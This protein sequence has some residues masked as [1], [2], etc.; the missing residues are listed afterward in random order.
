[1]LQLKVNLL[2]FNNKNWVVIPGGNTVQQILD[3][4]GRIGPDEFKIL[5]MEYVIDD[6][7]GSPDILK[8]GEI[9]S[10][11]LKAEEISFE[12]YEMF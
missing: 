2:K 4:I 3:L 12:L 8:A 1:M 11:Y 5:N 7:G 6:K 9:V 10:R